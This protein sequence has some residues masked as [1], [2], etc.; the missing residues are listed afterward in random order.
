MRLVKKLPTFL[1]P[2]RKTKQ[3]SDLTTRV[4]PPK[5]TNQQLP[6]HMRFPAL[7][8]HS[9]SDWLICLTG[10]TAIGQGNNDNASVFVFRHQTAPKLRDNLRRLLLIA[11]RQPNVFRTFNR[12]IQGSFF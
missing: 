3:Y 11:T 6:D 4:F 7:S 5:K 1:K 10:L 12:V 8:R 9:E 2:V